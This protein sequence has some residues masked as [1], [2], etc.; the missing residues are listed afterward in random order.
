V[1]RDLVEHAKQALAQGLDGKLSLVPLARTVGTSP[2]HLSRLF[3]RHTG[4]TLTAYHL[5]LRLR[6]AHQR[7]LEGEP[8][9]TRLAL[10][11]GFADHSHFT[12]AFRRALGTTPSELRRSG[13][14]R[15]NAGQ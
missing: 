13:G 9:L 7:I 3:H 2:F 10:E 1:H 12:T 11:L 5:S 4:L 8:D 15:R 6:A 14:A